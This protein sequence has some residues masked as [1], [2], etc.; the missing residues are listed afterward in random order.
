MA[1]SERVIRS[2]VHCGFCLAACPT[3]AL[4]GDE[5]ESPRGRIYLIKNMLETEAQPTREVV[6]HV[7]SCLS[8]LACMTA[9]PSG[10]DYRRLI[11][12][13]RRYVAERHQRGL[14]ERLLR[15]ALALVLPHEGRFRAALALARLGRPL[16]PL[17]RRLSGGRPLLASLAAMLALAP[18]RGAPKA[19]GRAPAEG[20]AKGRVVLLRG[21]AEPALQPEV[22]A[23]AMRV[24]AQAGYRVSLAKGEVCCGALEHHLDRETAALAAARRNID[25][26]TREIEAGALKAVIVTAS[27]CGAMVKDYGFMLRDDPVYAAKAAAVSALTRDIS[28]FLAAEPS[29]PKPPLG[30]RVAYHGA[31]ALQHGQG[32]GAEAPALLAAAGFEVCT[33]VEAQMCCGS[34]GVYNLLQPAAAQALGARKA[35]H[36]DRLAPDVIASGNIGC[37]MQIGAATATPVAHVVELLDWA[38]GGPAPKACPGLKGRLPS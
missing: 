32:L 14:G 16:A 27:G 31:C 35:A 6:R 24:L 38:L 15:G 11:D 12:H 19:L 26:W 13:A 7:D 33:P 3:Y 29:T 22:R 10:V 5:L 21:C 9:C 17:L 23:A 37:A 18:A 4:S 2:C 28:E 8:C 1:R 34:A 30:V 36:L 20:G 25:A